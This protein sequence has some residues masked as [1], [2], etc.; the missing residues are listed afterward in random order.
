MNFRRTRIEGMAGLEA[1]AARSGPWRFLILLDMGELVAQDRAM[2]RAKRGEAEA[3]R[4][5]SSRH[6]QRADLLAEQVGKNPVE[7][8]RPAVAVIGGVEMVR[9]DQRLQHLRTGSGG[10]VGEKAHRRIA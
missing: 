1:Y 2:R 5:R 9:G 3:I 7:L 8:L 4:R 6:P 10:I